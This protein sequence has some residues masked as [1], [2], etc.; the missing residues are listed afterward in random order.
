[1][2]SKTYYNLCSTL[3]QNEAVP[4]EERFYKQACAEVLHVCS[5]D[6]CKCVPCQEL[7]SSCG[8]TLITPT[9]LSG[10]GP[11]RAYSFVL[12]TAEF[13]GRGREDNRRRKSFRVFSA[14]PFLLVLVFQHAISR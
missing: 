1:M 4:F 5:L 12:H 3:L 6:Q 9:L 2:K 7:L 11:T 13:V 8:H 14:R 10:A